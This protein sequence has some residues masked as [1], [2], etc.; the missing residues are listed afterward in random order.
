MTQKKQ[1]KK[2]VSNKETKK[3]AKVSNKETQKIEIP[4]YV[5]EGNL[6]IPED[7]K[8]VIEYFKSC[9]N[10]NY[11][12]CLVGEKESVAK[13]LK[14]QGYQGDYPFIH[15]DP[16]DIG[17]IYAFLP[18]AVKKSI[19]NTNILVSNPETLFNTTN[20][21]IHTLGLVRISEIKSL[22]DLGYG[23]TFWN[24][25]GVFYNG[26]KTDA[27]IGG[28]GAGIAGAGVAKALLSS[29]ANDDTF[30]DTLRSRPNVF[31]SQSGLELGDDAVDLGEVA[32]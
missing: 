5:L 22:N 9:G 29:D 13:D 32:A 21:G 1:M 14:E 4:K 20:L 24:G 12:V 6:N 8:N 15:F 17:G 18:E 28:V 30:S 31:G 10:K 11:Q 26:F 23:T 16:K 27:I 19:R 3:I 2:K 7:L 25:L